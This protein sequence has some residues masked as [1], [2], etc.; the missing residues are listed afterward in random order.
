MMQGEESIINFSMMWRLSDKAKSIDLTDF[1]PGLG[2]IAFSQ[3]E[4]YLAHIRG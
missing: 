1:G 2:G 3:T 4:S